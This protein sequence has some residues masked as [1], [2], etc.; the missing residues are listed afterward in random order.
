[1]PSQ[2]MTLTKVQ[3]LTCFLDLTTL[4]PRDIFIKL[5]STGYIRA[6]RLVAICIGI[7][8]PYWSFA[9]LNYNPA[10]ITALSKAYGF[11]LGQDYQLSRIEKAYPAARVEVEMT[12][13]AFGAGFPNIR[14]KIE[15][16]LSSALGEAGLKQLRNETQRKIVDFLSQQPMTS[17]TAKQFLDQVQARAKGNEIEPDVLNYLLAVKY[18]DNNAGEF[19]DGFRQRYRT[20]GS[21]KSQGLR[22]HL[23]LPRSWLAVE[24]ERPHV[25][26]KWVSEGGTGLANIMLLI[27]DTG[28]ETPNRAEVDQFVQS[29]EIRTIVPDGGTYIDGGA[30]SMEKS[31]GY[32]LE[33][34]TPQERAGRKMYS[35]GYMYLLFFQGKAISLICATGGAENE[36]TKV[37]NASAKLKPLCQQVM[38]S[39]VL[40]QAY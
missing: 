20:D 8:F 29:G 26:K 33:M 32:W 21:G 10:A 3:D 17:E 5:N 37:S 34:A 1:M 11:I 2:A 24:G 28:G 9:A 36:E 25:V 18:T 38:N 4:L 35:H 12:R 7:V 27:Q 31:A 19:T 6:L 13:M 40:D 16:E 22:F 39:V 30:L 23:Q 14:I 15:R